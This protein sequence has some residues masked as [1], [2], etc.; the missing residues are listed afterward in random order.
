[1]LSKQAI[2]DV[3]ADLLR[4]AEGILSEVSFGLEIMSVDVIAYMQITPN[5]GM[6]PS[7]GVVYQAKGMLI[8]GGYNMQ[9]TGVDDPFIPEEVLRQGLSDG[10]EMLRAARTQQ[11][12]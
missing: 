5:G 8:G 12:N 10:C 4:R 7:W 6:R 1:M 3:R 2:V 11:G 9:M